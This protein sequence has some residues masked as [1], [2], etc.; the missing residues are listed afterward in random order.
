MF[1]YC[2][3]NPVMG[4]DP[5]GAVD[6]GTF[7]EGAGLMS[8]GVTAIIVA[9]AVASGGACV[10][11][12]IAAGATFAAGGM[13]LA[14]G[15][16]EVVESTTGYNYMRD[17][18]Y[19]GNAGFYEGQKAVFETAAG[20]GT[21]AISAASTSPR[22]CFAAG[23]MILTA[24]GA[25][26]IET[27]QAGDYVWAW[28]EET[29]DV[30]LKKVVETYINETDEF[31]HVFVNGEEI[32]TTPTHPFYSPVKGWTKAVHL[33]AG[34]ILILV[35]GEYVVV[36]KIQHEILASPV[37]VYNFQVAGYHTYF[38]TDSGVLVHNFCGPTSQN[39][40]QRQVERGQVPNGVDRVDPPHTP[41]V[42]N[43]QP[44]VHFTDGTAINQDGSVHDA[45]KGIPTMTAKIVKWLT[46][47]GWG[48][49]RE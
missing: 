38:V 1:A 40:M 11:L 36:E 19:G 44:H 3:N 8:V 27:V 28:D 46:N 18:M 2:G 26:A 24:N 49:L 30:A 23:T 15:V 34:D 43:S 48:V 32:I 17:G 35:N 25:Q 42:G 20:V 13:T 39:Q 21:M 41:G 31:I 16:A 6:W 37:I 47:N 33:R 4:Y 10:P 5:T 12:L 7:A 22:V 14:N 45:H 9:A 29:G